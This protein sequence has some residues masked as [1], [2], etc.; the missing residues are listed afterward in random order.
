LIGTSQGIIP[1][2]YI[3]KMQTFYQKAKESTFED[4]KAQIEETCEKKI[5]D[6]FDNFDQA[7]I[8]AASIAQVH[9]AYLK[10]GQKVAVKVQHRWLKEQC[11]GDLRIIVFLT[12]LAEIVFP[13]FKYK[14]YGKELS[15]FLPRELDFLGEAR[16]A[17]RTGELFKNNPNILV[18][19]VYHEYSNVS[20]LQLLSPK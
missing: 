10:D 2:E 1:E 20:N 5:E 12:H 6:I 4:V 15:K 14:W 11:L 7:P 9:V 17:E 13:G 18:P 19:K 3:T 8:S 16:N